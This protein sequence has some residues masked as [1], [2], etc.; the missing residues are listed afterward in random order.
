[1]KYRRK[2]RN[3]TNQQIEDFTEVDVLIGKM[4]DEKVINRKDI[5]PATICLAILTLGSNK[6]LLHEYY[7]GMR[8]FEKYWRNLEKNDYVNLDGTVNFDKGDEVT[9][10][11]LMV[12][13]AEGFIARSNLR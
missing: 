10:F 11:N 1:M 4:I 13:C 2:K 6:R 3:F 5:N 7:R 12:L 9:A 8:H